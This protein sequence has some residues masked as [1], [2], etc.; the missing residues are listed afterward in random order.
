MRVSKFGRWR[1]RYFCLNGSMLTYFATFPS[2]EFL[3]QASKDTF[4]LTDGTQPCG[5]VRVAHVDECDHRLGF[6]VFGTCG[7]VIDIRAGRTDERN[8]WLRALKTPARRKSRSWSVG[9]MSESMRSRSMSSFASDTTRSTPDRLSI[10]ILTCGWLLKQSD[11]LR[12][13]NRY[14]FVVQGGMVSYHATDKPYDVPR[15]RGYVA[16]VSVVRTGQGVFEM[17][18]RLKNQAPINVRMSSEE[19]LDEWR[20]HLLSCVPDSE[21]TPALVNNW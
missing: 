1:H 7:K 2:E 18:I 4:Y 15:R 13:W 17:Q 10:P 20:S 3:R 14:F 9:N 19:E 16:G 21:E 8:E 11:V 6:K 12:R 5:V